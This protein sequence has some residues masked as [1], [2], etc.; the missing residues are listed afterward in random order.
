MKPEK[1]R[2]LI[3]FVVFLIW[4]TRELMMEIIW[5]C[6]DENTE[7]LCGVRSRGE[8]EKKPLELSFG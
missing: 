5:D 4:L 2:I 6:E 7:G 1:V 8:R 3:F